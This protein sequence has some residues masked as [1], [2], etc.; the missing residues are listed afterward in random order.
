MSENKCPVLNCQSGHMY[1]VEIPD[2]LWMRYCVQL[3][4][5]GHEPYPDG[6]I[7]KQCDTCG[8]LIVYPAKGEL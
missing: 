3:L 7:C 1:E 2:Y 4:A 5:Q 8:I 6:E